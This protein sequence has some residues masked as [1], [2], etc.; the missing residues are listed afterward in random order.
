MHISKKKKKKLNEARQKGERR[1]H[2]IPVQWVKNSLNETDT[3]ST[4]QAITKID[5]KINSMIGYYISFKIE[6]K[7]RVNKASE[8]MTIHMNRIYYIVRP[9][10]IGWWMLRLLLL[11]VWNEI[12]RARDWS[13]SSTNQITLHTQTKSDTLKITL[14]T[15]IV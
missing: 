5:T 15:K 12:L 9:F 3:I 8:G 1:I 10:R 2:F 14:L 7:K 13:A 11:L 6:Y 4:W